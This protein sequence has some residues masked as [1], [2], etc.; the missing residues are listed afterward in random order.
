M[1]RKED[2]DKLALLARIH[3]DEAEKESLAKE[4]D[5]ILAYVAQLKQAS[6]DAPVDSEYLRNVFRD[7]ASPHESGIFTD[8]LLEASPDRAGQYF[9][10]KK[11]LN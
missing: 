9:K 1:I 11:I 7:D 3:I 8:K 2:I 6:A 10:V 4:I 5:A